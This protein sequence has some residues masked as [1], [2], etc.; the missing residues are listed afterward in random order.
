MASSS[1]MD[2]FYFGRLSS[3]STELG[4]APFYCSLIYARMVRFHF[5]DTP[6][7][8]QTGNGKVASYFNLSEFLF[9]LSSLI[10]DDLFSPHM[11]TLV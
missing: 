8:H 2:Y 10:G 11:R 9:E 6:F 5:V 1:W 3:S 4:D 7:T